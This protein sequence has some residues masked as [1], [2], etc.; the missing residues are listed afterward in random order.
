MKELQNNE[1]QHLIREDSDHAPLHVTCNTTQEQISKPFRFLNFCTEHHSFQHTVEEIWKMEATGSPFAVVQTK[2]KRVKSALVQWSKNTFGNIVQQVETL[3][4]VVKSKEI[5][6]EINPL[7]EN[8]TAL[9]IAE[10]NLKRY[11]KI[12][13]K[14]Y[15]QK[16]GMR[17]FQDG[18]KNTKFFTPM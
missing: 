12:E 11:L 10:A 18:D 16:A 2:L 6:L 7:G 1:V 13:E 17:W 8:R 5:Q 15:K 3:E 9:K 4:D 14:Y